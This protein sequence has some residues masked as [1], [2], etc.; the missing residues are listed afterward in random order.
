ML[1]P[2]KAQQS[3]VDDL[4]DGL[5]ELRQAQSRLIE[6]SEMDVL[7]RLLETK[8]GRDQL[9]DILRRLKGARGGRARG[10]GGPGF[11]QVFILQPPGDGARV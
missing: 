8:A 3:S 10:V 1:V 6:S 4:R 9:E 5:A 7:R 11:Y 2:T